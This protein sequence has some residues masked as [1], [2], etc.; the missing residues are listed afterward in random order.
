MKEH[1]TGESL[2][3]G[4]GTSQTFW[5][6]LEHLASHVAYCHKRPEPEGILVTSSLT[7]TSSAFLRGLERGSHS[8]D[9]DKG[10]SGVP[11]CTA[12]SGVIKPALE[13][14]AS[15]L[16]SRTHPP[17]VLSSRQTLAETL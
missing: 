13:Q 4:D 1:V 11:R 10:K 2:S 15:G 9:Y 16:G 5:R 6:Y 14:P 3:G 8:Y 17:A 12:Q 7:P